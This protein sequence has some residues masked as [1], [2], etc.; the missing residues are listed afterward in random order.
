L[1]LV[2]CVSFEAMRQRHLNAALAFDPH[3]RAHGFRRW[4]GE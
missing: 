4:S 1:S 3:F 2:D